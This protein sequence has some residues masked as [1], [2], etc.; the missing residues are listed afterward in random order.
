[1]MTPEA[2]TRVIR[3]VGEVYALFT[4]AV[5]Q[6]IPVFERMAALLAS[7]RRSRRASMQG[8]FVK[9]AWYAQEHQRRLAE[10]RADEPV[11]VEVSG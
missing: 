4:N 11:I 7:N 1:M 10:M 6:V 2:I 9:A 3:S 8:H 5:R